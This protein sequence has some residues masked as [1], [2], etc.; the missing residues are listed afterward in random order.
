M[1]NKTMVCIAHNL[2]TIRDSDLIYVMENG[3]VIEKGNYNELMAL[4]GVFYRLDKRNK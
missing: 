3:K 2:S 1:K 4:Q